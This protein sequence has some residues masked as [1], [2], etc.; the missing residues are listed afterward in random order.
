MN[1]KS[2]KRFT[3]IVILSLQSLITARRWKIRTYDKY[4]FCQKRTSLIL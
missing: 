3:S 2:Q 4:Q 1:Y